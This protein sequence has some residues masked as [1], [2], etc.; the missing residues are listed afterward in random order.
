MSAWITNEPINPAALLAQVGSEE[1]GAV[2]LFVGTVRC[3]NEGRQVI[4]I[5]YDAYREMAEGVLTEIVH[6]A[7]NQVS[8]AKVAAAHRIGELGIGECSVAIAVS[9]P[10]RADAF[11]LA[12]YVIEEI[13]KRLPVWKHEAYADGDQSWVKGTQP[14]TKQAVHE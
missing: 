2:V 12:R 4:G 10:H 9:T 1:D 13:K 8:G 11:E 6:E 7:R 5:R 14:P 3:S